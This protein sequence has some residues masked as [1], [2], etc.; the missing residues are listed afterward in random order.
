MEDVLGPEL[1]SAE[2]A[3]FPVGCGVVPGGGL[4]GL[5]VPGPRLRTQPVTDEQ[6]HKLRPAQVPSLALVLRPVGG[7]HSL[8]GVAHLLEVLECKTE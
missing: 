7:Q 1:G 8:Q 6:V 5:A 2:A 4:Q 3:V